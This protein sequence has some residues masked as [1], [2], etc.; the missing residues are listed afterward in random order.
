M[1]KTVLILTGTIL[2]QTNLNIVRDDTQVRIKDYEYAINFYQNKLDPRID[3]IFVENSNSINLLKSVDLNQSRVKFVQAPIDSKSLNSGK[4]AG[5]FEMLKYLGK[6]GYLSNY[7]FIWKVT[8]RIIIGNIKKLSADVNCEISVFRY[9][10]THSCDTKFFGMNKENFKLFIN[11]PIEFDEKSRDRNDLFSCKFQS[12]ENY[13]AFFCT[14]R[15]ETNI[16]ISSPKII[17]HYKGVSASTGKNLNTF[18]FKIFYS[19]SLLFRG[20]ALKLIGSF[21]P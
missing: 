13:L 12:I 10:D 2:P 9:K 11:Q 19:F 16:D 3:I 18:K 14:R 15:A 1:K 21:L 4:S 20:V 17:P 6:N 5:E 8:G 7:D